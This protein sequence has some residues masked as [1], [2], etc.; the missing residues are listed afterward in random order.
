[1]KNLK[2]KIS[3]NSEC[4]SEMFWEFI[5]SDITFSEEEV[6]GFI[7][8]LKPLREERIR[9]FKEEEESNL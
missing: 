1:M 6:K 4:I 2:E 9:L 3:F 5:D 7:E 8:N